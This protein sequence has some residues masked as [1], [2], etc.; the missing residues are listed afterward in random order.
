LLDVIDQLEFQVPELGKAYRNDGTRQP[1]VI[2]TSN[3]ERQL[4]PPFLRRCVFH[5]IEF[6]RSQALKR[7]LEER[8][9]TDLPARLVDA[10]IARFQELRAFGDG[11][12][13]KPSTSELVAWLKVLQLAG[14]DAD[15]LE[16]RKLSDLPSRGALIKTDAD[17]RMIRGQAR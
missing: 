7:I 17:D 9:G 10:A 3:S 1:I 6:P 5:Y 14:I 16:R 4:P 2:I 12:E 13:K 8:L 15:D 11:L